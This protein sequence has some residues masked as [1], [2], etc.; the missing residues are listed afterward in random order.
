MVPQNSPYAASITSQESS[1]GVY[2]NSSAGWVWIGNTSRDEYSGALF[3]LAVAYDMVG[4]AATKGTISDLVTRMVDFLESH[5]WSVNM[6]DGSISTSF[7][8]RPDQIETMLGI[9]R[10]VNSDHFTSLNYQVQR[11]LYSVSVPVPISVDTVDDSS[12]FKFNL[13]YI[14]LYNLVRLE[15]SSAVAIYSA[16]YSQLRNHTAPHQNAFFDVIDRA[17]NGPNA[18]RDAEAI[19][20]LDAWLLRLRRDFHVDLTGTVPMCGSDACTPVPVW[21]RPNTDFLWQ[22]SPFTLTVSGGAGIIETA[23]IDYILPYWM[24]R[25]SGLQESVIVT[26]SAAPIEVVAPGSLGT[27]YGQNLASTTQQATGLP[28][29]TFLADTSVTVRDNAG[30]SSTA[31]LLYVS[32]TQI[33]FLVPAGLATGIATFTIA[34]GT[35]TPITAMGAVGQVGPSLF[36][37]N[38]AGAGIAAASAFRAGGVALDLTRP[39]DLSGPAP[40]YLTLYG[41]GIRNFSSLNNVLVTIGGVP[42]QVLYAGPQPDFAGLDQINVQL[43]QALQGSGIA[44]IVL[45]VDQHQANTVTV[46]IQ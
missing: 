44:N 38:G 24:A 23:G 33:N 27:I 31:Q 15:T 40:V 11:D 36:S 42:L 20:L 17:L 1:N 4:D 19:A 5:N 46:N 18:S 41:T 34:S 28:L 9:G 25:Y 14:N 39:I 30:Q 22:R 45:K 32:P 16:A 29:P 8:I 12:Y 35:A 26:S 3:G 7:L 10:H 2:T 21:L 13:D 6:P 43:P 37:M